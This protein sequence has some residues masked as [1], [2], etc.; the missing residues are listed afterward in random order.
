M[1]GLRVVQA[2]FGDCLVLEFGDNPRR[3]I[4]ID[5]GP[6]LTYDRHLKS[7][8]TGIANGGGQLEVVVLSHV[9]GDHIEGLI[10]FFTDL[11]D[12]AGPH[13]IAVRGLWMNTFTKSP[14][15]SGLEPKIRALGAQAPATMAAATVQTI[16]EGN[17]L[18]IKA[19]QIGVTVND[20]FPDRLVLVDTAPAPIPFGDLEVRV[21]GPTQ[22]NLDALRAEWEKWIEKHQDAVN[23]NDPLLMANSDRSI[24]NLSS[25][26]LYVKQGTVTMLLTGD[27]RSDHL[28]DGLQ[29]AGLLAGGT[30]HVSLL[31]LPHH[32]SDRD[33][34]KAFFHK[35]TADKYVVSANGKDG[36]PDVA[37]LI[38][39]V[40]AAKED[41][42]PIKIYA[43]NETPSIEKLR[44]EYDA[45]EYG[46]TLDLL[47]PGDSS[48]LV[49]V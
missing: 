14:E 3:F 43:T 22:A 41:G 27:G 48:M 5:G 37:T 29:A 9:D 13:Y 11:R 4:L 1:F 33:I 17:D 21:V 36:N 38:W 30:M 12:A 8:L 25:I 19:A 35:V 24:P 6:N 16:G 7:V 32:G 42:R 31:K 34:T 46:Y 26:M 45:T 39:L 49:A 2:E 28:L 18:T 23:A 47:P 44:S 10:D 15:A 20:G 40:E